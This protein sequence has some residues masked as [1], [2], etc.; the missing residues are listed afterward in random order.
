M[1]NEELKSLE[2]YNINKRK[3][4]KKY[5]LIWK[6]MAGWD[7]LGKCSYL[8]Q[9]FYKEWKTEHNEDP[10]PSDFAKYYFSHTNPNDNEG[11]MKEN[12]Q[13]YGRSVEDLKALAEHYQKECN[14]YDIPL[15]D[16][17]DDVV[18]HAI[19]ETTLGQLREIKLFEE[20]ENKGFTVEHTSDH[21]DKN[22]GVDLIIKKDGIIKDYIQCKPIST[23]RGNSNGSLVDDR[24]MFFK[25]EL[26][27]KKECEQ[28]NMPYYPTKFILYDSRK[29]GKWCYIGEKR[30]FL[31]EELCDKN[32]HTIMEVDKVQ[33]R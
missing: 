13:D 6:G 11:I 24:K 16:Y 7:Y 3:F 17:F 20:Y 4:N 19:V 23:F 32:G 9:E 10:T 2:H 5:N 28:L 14:N 25:K 15:E 1:I 22:L 29:P 27:K 12:S 21:W 30:G 31:L 33:Y 8:F 26:D 18:N